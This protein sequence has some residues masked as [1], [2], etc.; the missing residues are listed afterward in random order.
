M[1][2]L[3]GEQ[4]TLFRSRLLLLPLLHRTMPMFR[5]RPWPW[6]L[7]NPN[8]S[9]MALPDAPVP[10]NDPQGVAAF[11]HPKQLVDQR[12]TTQD[13]KVT[14]LSQFLSEPSFKVRASPG[15]KMLVRLVVVSLAL[16][17]QLAFCQP[18]ISS[19][20]GVSLA[21]WDIE[22]SVQAEGGQGEKGLKSVPRAEAVLAISGKMQIVQM[23]PQLAMGKP[24]YEER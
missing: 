23:K 8:V 15:L 9:P 11:R 7:T 22:F 14:L 10:L 2:L 3:P 13:P 5:G 19:L 6:K 21:P 18:R 17:L 16:A 24:T 4:L 12:A 1:A 20:Y